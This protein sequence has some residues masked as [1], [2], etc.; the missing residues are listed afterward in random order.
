MFWTAFIWGL[1]ATLGGSIGLMSFVAMKC[2]WD[3]VVNTKTAQRANDLAGLANAALIR[4]NE[5]TEKQIGQLSAISASLVTIADA[6]DELAD[7][8]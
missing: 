6:A 4:R 1:G 7:G 3:I 2:I 5:L 8:Q